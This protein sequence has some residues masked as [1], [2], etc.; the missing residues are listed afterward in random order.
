MIMLINY[1]VFCVSLHIKNAYIKTWIQIAILYNHKVCD[2][3]IRHTPLEGLIPRFC[4]TVIR[5]CSHTVLF[6]RSIYV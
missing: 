4:I 3:S 1:Q 5:C 6:K 2:Y